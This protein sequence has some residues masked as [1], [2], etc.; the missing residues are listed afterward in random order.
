MI[1]CNILNNQLL[2]SIG[3]II[4]TIGSYL[5]WRYITDINFVDKD[6]YFKGDGVL[7]VQ[8]P[9]EDDIKLLKK[10]IRNSKIGYYLIV[11][12]GLLQILSNHL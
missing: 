11:L 9:S 8:N 7:K 2:N 12:G 6:A 1:Y 3:I 5:V 4:T 10:S